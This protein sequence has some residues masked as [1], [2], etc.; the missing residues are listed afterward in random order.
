MMSL[1]TCA[2]KV[3]K[4]TC[5]PEDEAA[6][7]FSHPLVDLSFSSPGTIPGMLCG[8]ETGSGNNSPALLEEPGTL[9]SPNFTPSLSI[10][11]ACHLGS[12]PTE[13]ELLTVQLPLVNKQVLETREERAGGDTGQAEGSTGLFPALL[14]HFI[15]SISPFLIWLYLAIDPWVR[16]I[17][18]RRA[19]QP[20]LIFLPGQSYG[21]RSL[22]DCSPW[23]HK[24]SAMTERL[25]SDTSSGYSKC[26]RWSGSIST[27][28]EL[29]RNAGS[30]LPLWAPLP[31]FSPHQQRESN[32]ILFSS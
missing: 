18:W 19:Q 22:A 8:L 16:K 5:N 23:G 24:E 3:F 29:V 21:Q 17:P 20:T 2:G 12:L 30:Q 4:T 31:F 25:S 13:Q 28:W 32:K 14:H 11:V 10:C 6:P 1:I 9:R 7:W 15:F 26:G 27:T